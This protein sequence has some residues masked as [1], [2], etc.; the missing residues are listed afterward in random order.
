M[1]SFADI[2]RQVSSSDRDI[3]SV[4]P[5]CKVTFS[6]DAARLRAFAD[7]PTTTNEDLKDWTHCPRCRTDRLGGSEAAHPVAKFGEM[8]QK[9][10]MVPETIDKQGASP[11][12]TMTRQFVQKDQE[13]IWGEIQREAK[14]FA[15]KRSDLGTEPE[16]ISEYLRTHPQRYDDYRA[17]PVTVAES[18]GETATQVW[19]EI[20]K[21]GKAL[22]DR[23]LGKFS[24]AEANV[25]VMERDPDLHRRYREAQRAKR[26]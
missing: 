10:G 20:E 7:S 25:M 4:C 6:V 24:E 26:Y 1:T 18:K 22:R 14:T 23:H 5:G 19:S 3:Q 13:A 12:K 9:P 11:A 21:Q 17:A 15:E 8:P 2:G 16:A